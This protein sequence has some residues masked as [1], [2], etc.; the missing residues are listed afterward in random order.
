M[1]YN[2]FE[3]SATLPQVAVAFSVAGHG[4]GTQPIGRVLFRT[5]T[6]AVLLILPVSRTIVLL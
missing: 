4:C 3:M 6:L 1:S 2:A 5:M